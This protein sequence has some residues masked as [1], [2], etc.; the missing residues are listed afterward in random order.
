MANF[1]IIGRI[2]WS[3][4]NRFSAILMAVPADRA[5]SADIPNKRSLEQ[6]Y[7]LAA[8]ELRKM[9]VRMGEQLREEGH[10]VIN[11]EIEQ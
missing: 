10:E 6:T 9:A 7:Q 8:V 5:H 3:G 2:E 11:V 1:H 4:E